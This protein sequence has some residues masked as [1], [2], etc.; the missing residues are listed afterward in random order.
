MHTINEL[1]MTIITRTGE[2]PILGQ[3]LTSVELQRISESRGEATHISAFWALAVLGL[4]LVII[5]SIALFQ[6]VRSRHQRPQPLMLFRKVASSVG[7]NASDQL[8]LWRIAKKFDLPSPLT[9]MLSDHTL[10]HYAMAYVQPLPD[11]RNRQI[12][13]RITGI[14]RYLFGEVTVTP[15]AEDNTDDDHQEAAHDNQPR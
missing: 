14:R 15:A 4:V 8:L 3:R 1:M 6:W 7:L 13:N 10:E 5:S 2:L 12:M 11:S 9:L